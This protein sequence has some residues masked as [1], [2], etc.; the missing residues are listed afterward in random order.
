MNNQRL[1]IYNLLVNPDALQDSEQLE[2]TL[3]NDIIQKIKIANKAR[4]TDINIEIVIRLIL[5]IINSDGFGLDPLITD[6][7]NK[8]FLDLKDETE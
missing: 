3:P 6:K 2:L 1:A 7:A 4:D 8:K 5:T